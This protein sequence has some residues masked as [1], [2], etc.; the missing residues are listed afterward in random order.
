MNS[1]TKMLRA[2]LLLAALIPFSTGALIA[3]PATTPTPTMAPETPLH[4]IGASAAAAAAAP[5]VAAAPETRAPAHVSRNHNG[6]DDR[7]TVGDPNHIKADET[8]LNNAVSVMGPLT[9]DGVVYGN[10]VSVMGTNT[11]NGKVSGNAVA[12]LGDLTLGPGAEVSGNAVSV[13]GHVHKDPAAIVSGN[14]VPVN[15]GIA[16]SENEDGAVSSFWKHG[17]RWGRPVG[18]GPHMHLFWM[19]NIVLIA[20]YI[21][22]VAVFPGG[23]TKCA[24]TLER[25]PGITFL[26]GFLAM[27][28][29]PV[30]FILLL[31]T[32]VGIPVALIVLPLGAIACT[33]FGKAALYS[34]IGRSI[35]GRQRRLVLATLVG[36][37]VILAFYLVP[38]LGLALWFL[39]AFLGFSC[40]LATLFSPGASVAP[41]PAA[42]GAPAPA[43]AGYPADVATAALAVPVATQTAFGANPPLVEPPLAAAPAAAPAPSPVA[44]AVSAAS[45]TSLPR[46]GFW[47]RMVA[48]LIDLVLICMVFHFPP[49]FLPALAAYAAILWKLKGSTIGGIIFGLKVV[50]LEAKPMDWVTAV[51]RALACFLSLIFLGLGFIWIGFDPQKQAWHDKIAGTVVVRLPKGVSLV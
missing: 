44:S 36:I 39:V 12:V 20:L 9:V 11:I 27:L 6:E 47:I 7:V 21:A 2:W 41:A 1:Q 29:M 31:V 16:V 37:L 24:D 22:L 35:L 19:A 3:D 32:V 14:M 45:E 4:E 15:I 33:L 10:A 13:G 50:R 34:F 17:L 28:G 23:I 42:A 40:A 43:P 8:V 30:L 18:F 5:A 26:T 25:R 49:V 46:A 48:L 51:V 38:F